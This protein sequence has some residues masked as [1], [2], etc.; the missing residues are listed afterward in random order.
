LI[1]AAGVAEVKET[2]RGWRAVGSR[3]GLVPTMGY[4]HRGHASL[5]E[6]SVADC[7]RTVVSIFVNPT[8][9]G[10]EEDLGRYPRNEAADLE[11]CAARGV[12]LVFLPGA[13]SVVYP[14][15][16]CTRVEVDGL[17]EDLCGASRPTHFAGVTQV[18]CKLFNIVG[19][20]RAYFGRKD[21]QQLLVVRRMAL[22]LDMDVEVV[23]CPIVRES[24]G[25]A[26]S[27]RNAYLQSDQRRR[28]R[29]LHRALAYAGDRVAAGLRDAGA[30]ELAVREHI[31]AEL[32]PED[33]VDYVA[34]RDAR[35][36]GRVRKLEGPALLALA[37]FVGSTRLIDNTVLDLP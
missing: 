4:L 36:L 30:L 10:P 16:F 33:R 3:I 29:A 11:L 35:D 18:V 34:L 25:L 14:D 17:T 8:Q 20:D 19:P 13:P 37:V 15:G 32:A 5:I 7:D 22:D 31:E 21:Y 23:G 26:M 9:F 12:D 6:R 24:D 1:V 28:A 27:S 2:C